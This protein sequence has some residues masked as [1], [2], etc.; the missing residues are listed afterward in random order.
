MKEN[1]LLSL[2]QGKINLEDCLKYYSKRLEEE[3]RKEVEKENMNSY[4]YRRPISNN[5]EV[6][7][8]SNLLDLISNHGFVNYKGINEFCRV[9]NNNVTNILNTEGIINLTLDEILLKKK[10]LQETDF[11]VDNIVSNSHIYNLMENTNSCRTIFVDSGSKKSIIKNDLGSNSINASTSSNTIIKNENA[12]YNITASTGLASIDIDIDS[13]NS[14]TAN[15]GDN[16]LLHINSYNSIAANTGDG[17][18]VCAKGIG[19]AAISS[20]DHSIV[21]AESENNFAIGIGHNCI[22]KGKL[23]SYLILADWEDNNL[24]D[25]KMH[26]VDNIEIKEDV[27]YILKNGKFVE[28]N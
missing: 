11:N 5:E 23:G 6:E 26:I 17:S 8:Y 4:Y 27:Y 25:V 10:S 28:V 7:E 12:A 21:S 24:I 18:L 20:G 16:S 15:T 13:S 22:A 2:V 19:S 9:S 14:I 1:Y 3:I